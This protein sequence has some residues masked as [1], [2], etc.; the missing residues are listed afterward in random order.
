MSK[1][2]IYL[3]SLNEAT[4]DLVACQN[5][6]ECDWTDD[7]NTQDT[8]ECKIEKFVRDLQFKEFFTLKQQ[9][10][11]RLILKRTEATCVFKKGYLQQID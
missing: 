9:N 10:K 11:L 6:D 2:E 5:N 8:L 1:V 3:N 4:K 7:M